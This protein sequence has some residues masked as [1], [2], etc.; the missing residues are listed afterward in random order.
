VLPRGTL[1][2]LDLTWIHSE[3]YCFQIDVTRC[4]HA[5]G[6][7]IVEVPV[8]FVERER[9]R[10]KMSRAIIGE[11]LWRVTVWGLARLVPGHRARI[12]R[13]ALA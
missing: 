1:E 5:A 11:A 13:R 6:M 10:S 9:G 12:R 7:R 4:V 3:G 8:T 2:R